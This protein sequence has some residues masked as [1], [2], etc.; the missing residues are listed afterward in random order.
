M[1]K[2]R[3]VIAD[4]VSAPYNGKTPLERGL[5]GSES[6]VIYISEELVKLGMDVT[7]FC[8]TD[9]DIE[10]NGV[11]YRELSQMSSYVGADV[12]IC[13]R[14]TSYFT[15][16]FKDS[17]KVLWLHDTFCD[18]DMNLEFMLVN[19][20]IDEVWTLSDWHANY[21]TQCTHSHRRMM[22]VLKRK[23]WVTRNGCK[24]Y[25]SGDTYKK[26]FNQYV[27][28]AAV[29]KG[30]RVLLEEVWP[31]M[32]PECHLTV[33]GGAYVMRGMDDQ[34]E[35]LS[36]LIEKHNGKNRV[37][38]TG[39]IKQSDVCDIVSRAGFMI[40][41][42]TSPETY[43]ISVLESLAHGTPVITGR[44]GALEEVAIESACYLMD[45]PIDSVIHPHLTRSREDRIVEFVKMAEDARNDYYLWQQKS[46]AALRVREVC[47]WSAVA[48]QWK[49]HLFRVL[50][51]YLPVEETRRA[52][53]ISSRVRK[54]FN[55]K[56]SNQEDV[57]SDYTP[58]EQLRLNVIVPFHNAKDYINDCVRS[59]LSQNYENYTIT[60]ID[61]ASDDGYVIEPELLEE[62]NLIVNR[63]RRGA[64]RNQ[65]DV[66][67]SDIKSEAFVLVDGD[68]KLVNDPDVFLAINHEYH[69]RA[70]MTYGSCKSIADGIELIA[71]EYPDEVFENKSFREYDK[72]P[73]KIPYTHLRTISCD[74]IAELANTDYEKKFTDE[75]GEWYRAGGDAALFYAL[76]EMCDKKDV[77]VMRDVSYL[78]NDLNPINDYKVNS[79]EQTSA[80]HSII[81][82]RKR[83]LVAV[84]TNNDIYPQTFKSI[85][86]ARE[87]CRDYDVDFQ[88]FYGYCIDQVRNLICSYAIT[89]AYD[90]VFW[91]DHDI[92]FDRDALKKMLDSDLDIVTGLYRQRTE[93]KRYETYLLVDHTHYNMEDS[94]LYDGMI[95]EIDACGFGC[96][97]T[98]TEVLKRVGYPQFSYHHSIKMENSISEDVDFCM[99]AKT[100]GYKIVLDTT[101]KCGH[102]GKYEY[103]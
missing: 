6:A 97:L 85:Y 87:E 52:R 42:Q 92:T 33:I 63:D 14:S 21:V 40:Y 44:F 89:N 66:M 59:I 24:L 36:S 101:I 94:D 34:N 45:Y 19:D 54:I 74:L 49:Q 16:N 2:L 7:V 8:D 29:S 53:Y 60:L 77:R 55:R 83:V 43:G 93:E 75:N 4:P 70:K 91:V 46:Q 65:M 26:D 32:P 48:L 100:M 25:N 82:T 11:S 9:E 88:F 27:F 102:L 99:K 12:F 39:I 71:Q 23:V 76:I 96:V 35:E 10:W 56:W 50:G 86:D 28:N 81:S 15:S 13:S 37:T 78:Y 62:C 79:E 90:Y 22:E 80:L 69:N 47:E 18:G 64:L 31:A 1:T 103:R 30:L 3:V 41:P 38:F 61:D 95:E 68:D 20:Q 17:F 84:P 57:Y 51:K 72:F 5:G 98:K 58:E 67:L 73:W